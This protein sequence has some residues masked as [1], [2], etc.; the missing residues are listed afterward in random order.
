MTSCQSK[1]MRPSFK[2]ASATVTSL[3]LGRRKCSKVTNFLMLSHQSSC[4][5]Q[6]CLSCHCA[7]CGP[8]SHGER[9]SCLHWDPISCARGCPY[10]QHELLRVKWHEG[11]HSF[12]CWVREKS[13]KQGDGFPT[14]SRCLF[15]NSLIRPWMIKRLKRDGRF[16]YK[17]GL[18]F[19]DQ[20]DYS[21]FTL[22]P[23]FSQPLQSPC[24]D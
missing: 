13:F 7:C 12:K 24:Q 1:G 19:W 9:S 18:Y 21:G 17:K 10:Q 5:L 4:A 16:T 2:I 20:F 6:L 8:C 3:S 11:S 22:Y 15:G 23:L 14:D